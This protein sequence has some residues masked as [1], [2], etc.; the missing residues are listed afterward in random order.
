MSMNVINLRLDEA[1]IKRL[2][3]L[4]DAMKSAPA[5]MAKGGPSRS[6]V[7]RE[8]LSIGIRELEDT[9]PAED[10]LAGEEG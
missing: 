5:Y 6:D 7:M 9:W 1:T 4:M 2:D 10:A 3:A 8:A